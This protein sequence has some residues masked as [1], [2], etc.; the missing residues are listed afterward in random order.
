MAS[1]SRYRLIQSSS[2]TGCNLKQR[3]LKNT[4]S[5]FI[6]RQRIIRCFSTIGVGLRNFEEAVSQSFG[7][8]R[9]EL[10]PHYVPVLDGGNEPAA[11]I[12]RR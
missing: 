9:M 6:N 4:P 3:L 8:F 11:V 2:P 7:F 12:T 1:K 10:G 5:L